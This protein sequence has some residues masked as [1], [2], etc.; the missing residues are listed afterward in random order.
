MKKYV[1]PQVDELPFVS[2]STL[3]TAS[4]ESFE[5]DEFDPGFVTP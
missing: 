5:I 2:A 4:N 3:L 1:Q